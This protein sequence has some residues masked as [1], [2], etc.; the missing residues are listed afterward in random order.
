[1]PQSFDAELIQMIRCPVT[2][3][4]LVLAS[5]TVVAELNERIRTGAVVNRDGQPINEILEG[6]FL[7]QDQ[8]LLLPVRG[9]IVILTDDQAIPLDS[10]E[11]TENEVNHE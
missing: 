4:R 3:S 9:G 11:T 10:V 5:E 2:Q 1:M 8:S 7:N 6:G